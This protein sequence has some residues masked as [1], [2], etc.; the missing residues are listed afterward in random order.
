M[1]GCGKSGGVPTAGGCPA[2]KFRALC[3]Q[4]SQERGESAHKSDEALRMMIDEKEQ[5]LQEVPEDYKLCTDIAAL[6]V[7]MGD[8]D[9]ALEY[10][11]YV[12]NNSL[13][14][15]AYVDRSIADTVMRKYDEQLGMLD[16]GAPDYEQQAETI[17][18]EKLEFQMDDC[19]R[20]VDK[21][22][23]DMDIRYELG[24]LCFENG[25]L[26]EA[27]HALQRAQN[28]PSHRLKAL[29]M[30]GQC[31]AMQHKHDLAIRTFENG[32]KEKQIFDEGK[33]EMVY[34]LGCVLESAGRGEE[35]LEY[36]KSIYE[37]DIGYRDVK[38]R[39]DNEY[40]GN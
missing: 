19:R 13:G 30:L 20:R 39:V 31:F 36:F 34:H 12:Q 7:Q 35:A 22:P 6:Y 18:A 9:R 29:N 23:T 40:A 33:K 1:V 14:S 4:E 28:S 2:P 8:Y 38:Q 21:Y 25:E 3:Y 17:R 26:E 11:D 15:D 16:P 37:L 5:K 10:Y 27:L 32:I 24:K